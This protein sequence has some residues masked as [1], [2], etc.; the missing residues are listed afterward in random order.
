MKGATWGRPA[1]TVA[2]AV[3]SAALLVWPARGQSAAPRLL[4]LLVVDQMRAEY[5]T[6]FERHWERGFRRLI[7]QGS[8]FEHAA[9]PYANTVTCAGHATVA[10]GALPRTHGLVGN[11]WWDRDRG[12]LTD[13]TIDAGA[14]AAHIS[15]GRPVTSGNGPHLLAATTIGDE[16]RRQRPG[17]RVVSI[18]LKPDT[19]ITLAGHGGDVVAWFDAGAASFVTSQAYVPAAS[20]D[21][22]AFFS[23]HPLTEEFSATWTLRKSPDAY[24]NADATPG[25]RPPTGRD[26]LFPHAIG[27]PGAA[28]SVALWMQSPASDRYLGRMAASLVETR[29]LGADAAPDVLAIGFSALDL[30]GHGFGPDSREIEDVLINLDQTIGD[31]LDV[32]DRRV[33]P[34]GYVVALT[35]DHGVAPIPE[36]TGSGRVMTEDLEERIVDLLHSRWGAERPGAYAV[37][38]GPYVYFAHGILARLRAEPA[39]WRE[40]LAAITTHPGVLRVLSADELTPSAGDPIVRAAALSYFPGRSGDLVIVTKPGWVAGG[41]SGTAATS[42]GTPHDY[43]QRVPVVFFGNGIRAGRLS[44]AASPADIA[45]TLAHLAGITLPQAEGRVLREALR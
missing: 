6:L 1:L 9:Y 11:A 21:L 22:T 17:A 43:D 40:V 34:S 38:R 30:V 12:G 2:C 8:V 45:P 28:L 7:T 39:L 4:V 31:L 15:Y 19:A 25:Q 16:L 5:L 27:G 26:G 35:A 44:Q 10:T 24:I 41:R 37:V 32:L 33:G 14:D 3:L 42:H 29:A 36:A 18:S 13:C 20:A 23:T